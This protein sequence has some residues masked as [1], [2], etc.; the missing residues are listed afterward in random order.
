MWL[1]TENDATDQIVVYYSDSPYSTWSGPVTLATGVN[2]DD[3][4]VVTVLPS[5]NKIGVLW[6]NQN[7]KRF[8]FRTHADGTDPA[9]WTV[10]EVPASQS[11]LNV[12]LGM[13]DDHLNVATT[14]DGTLYAAVKTSYDTA[15]YPKIAL[16]V[17]RPGGTWDNL[18]EVDQAGTRSIVE[19]DEA[20]GVL[21]VIYTSSE[22]YGA[23][24]YKQSPLGTIVLRGQA[25]DAERELQR[26]VEHEEQLHRRVSGDLRQQHSS[27]R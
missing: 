9:T 12:G 16:L 6:S 19:V 23:I 13:A 18:Y 22:G 21:N 2:D 11:A 25:N 5:L 14:S 20:N 8:G 17:R 10:D 1:A 7:T 15:N 4:S 26:C 24:V 27:G 3:I